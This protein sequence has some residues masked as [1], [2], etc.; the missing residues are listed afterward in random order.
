MALAGTVILV[1]DH[2]LFRA[3]SHTF[4]QAQIIS[5]EKALQYLHSDILWETQPFRF[6]I[7]KR[8]KSVGHLSFYS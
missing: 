5:E 3:L 6:R 8:D 7:H 2:T 4:A 1:K